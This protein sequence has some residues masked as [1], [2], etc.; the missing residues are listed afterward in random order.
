MGKWPVLIV[1]KSPKFVH[2]EGVQ[3]MAQ[4][5]MRPCVCRGFCVGT[6]RSL[7]QRTRRLCA[8]DLVVGGGGDEEAVGRGVQYT[9]RVAFSA[10]PPADH[11]RCGQ[12]CP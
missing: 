11:S 4:Q 8:R 1:K 12:V 2:G 5:N 9:I 3:S 7:R 10:A 6:L